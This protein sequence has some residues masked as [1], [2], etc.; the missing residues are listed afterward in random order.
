M[1]TKHTQRKS[2]FLIA[3]LS[4]QVGTNKEI[5]LMEHFAFSLMKYW[6]GFQLFHCLCEKQNHSFQVCLLQSGSGSAAVSGNAFLAEDILEE[7]ND[8][9]YVEE[10]CNCCPEVFWCA[11]IA[12]LI[13][14]YLYISALLRRKFHQ[15]SAN[16]FNIFRILFW[17]QHKFK[18]VPSFLSS[19][20]SSYE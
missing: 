2:Q 11:A 17:L 6:H 3:P 8:S 20:I 16:F 14:S 4:H 5:T 13:T 7:C 15:H 10:I 19:Y 18:L 1:E 12:S 9:R